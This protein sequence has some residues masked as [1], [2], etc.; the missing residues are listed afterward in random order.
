[1]YMY[2]YTKIRNNTIGSFTGCVAGRSFKD[3]GCFVATQEPRSQNPESLR[4]PFK[5]G[6]L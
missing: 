2:L 1:M 4:I 6:P 3:Q 5:A